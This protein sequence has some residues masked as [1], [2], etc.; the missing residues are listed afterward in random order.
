MICRCGL[1][2]SSPSASRHEAKGSQAG[3]PPSYSTRPAPTAGLKLRDSMHG[4][5]GKN[6]RCAAAGPVHLLQ[7]GRP[8]RVDNQHEPMPSPRMTEISS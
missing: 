4:L 3:L 7:T 8:N 5:P 2:N 1:R 6:T